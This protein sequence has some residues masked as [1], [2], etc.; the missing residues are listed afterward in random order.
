MM[1]ATGGVW[2]VGT[3]LRKLFGGG[4]DDRVSFAAEISRPMD[5]RSSVRADSR[6]WAVIPLMPR[7]A[8]GHPTG[9]ET[10]RYL[11]VPPLGRVRGTQCHAVMK[12]TVANGARGYGKMTA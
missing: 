7:A 4:W 6:S 11:R 12:D 2:L 9:T 10:E 8:G 3:V 1:C 5:P